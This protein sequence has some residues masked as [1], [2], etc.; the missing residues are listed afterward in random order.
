MH[1]A[2]MRHD[3]IDKI[4][5]KTRQTA[6]GKE[7]FPLTPTLSLVGEREPVRNKAF[8]RRIRF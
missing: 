7:L 4:D 1:A 2:V 6:V 8:N 5:K 3:Q